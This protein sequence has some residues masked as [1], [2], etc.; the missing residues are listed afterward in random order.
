MYGA[1]KGERRDG[2]GAGESLLETGAAIT[3]IEVGRNNRRADEET[4]API[5]YLDAKVSSP[6]HFYVRGERLF[7][8]SHLV[9]E[10]II[11]PERKVDAISE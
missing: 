10:I 7:R 8:S 5:Q 11:R 6:G 2:A 4:E 9:S 3:D 1:D